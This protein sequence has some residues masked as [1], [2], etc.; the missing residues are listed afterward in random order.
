VAPRRGEQLLDVAGGT[1][2]IAF[3]LHRRSRGL[4]QIV[5]CDI[6]ASMLEVGRNRAVDR[7]LMQGI[8][9]LTGDAEALPF[10]DRQFDAYTVA[11][12]LRNVTFPAQAL[13]EA[14][15]VLK[16]G[17]RLCCLEFSRLQWPGVRELYD[18]WSARALPLLGRL[19]AGD[20]EAYRYLHESIRHFPSQEALAGMMAEAGLGNVSWRNLAG[21]AVALHCAWR[22]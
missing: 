3:R 14:R 19:I 5:V 4:A 9:W 21:G 12:G 10:A 1:G 6:N 15:R 18:A 22:I 2:V 17:G 16:P 7:G 8:E 11:F 13:R 20:G